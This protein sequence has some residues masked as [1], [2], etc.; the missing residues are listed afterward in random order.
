M[1][2]RE[3][4][5]YLYGLYRVLVKPLIWGAGNSQCTFQKCKYILST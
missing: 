4:L 3:D 5:H 1:I 2:K